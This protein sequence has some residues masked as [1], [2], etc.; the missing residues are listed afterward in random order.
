MIS[1]IGRPEPGEF[2][3]YA[4][5][6]IEKVSGAD[7]AAAL[8]DQLEETLN[9]LRPIDESTAA[10]RVY[11]PGK[12]TLKQVV[13]H[14]SDDER[15]F[16]YRCLCIARHDSRE[17]PGFDEKLYAE[18]ADFGARR[19]TDLL[20]EFAVVRKASIALFEGLS[21]DAWMRRG[22]VNG[23]SATVR[24]LAYHMAG[25]EL[26]HIDIIRTRYL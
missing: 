6:D 10:T 2:A 7:V 4:S 17:L 24:G 12:W 8:Q 25:H 9:L 13:G 18:H 5:S 19:F 26:H 11:A 16:A 22:I 15:I 23:Y 21:R 3:D 14:M 1:L 20:E